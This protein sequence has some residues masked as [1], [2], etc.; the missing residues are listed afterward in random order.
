MFWRKSRKKFTKADV[1]AIRN[2]YAQRI[3]ELAAENR[4]L[5]RDLMTSAQL[6]DALENKLFVEHG[7]QR[8]LH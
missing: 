4:D 5:K 1:D 2:H 6:I 3:H 8:I 7:C